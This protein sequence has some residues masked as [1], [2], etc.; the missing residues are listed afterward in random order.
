MIAAPGQKN[1]CGVY[2]PTETLAL[3]QPNRKGWRGS[4]LA[5]IDI[6]RTSEG[7]RAVHGIQFLTGSCWGSSSPLMD[8]D[9]AFNSRDAA[10]EHQVA[11][12][13]ERVTKYGEREPG[14]LRD[15]RA[16]L[17]WLDNLRPVQADL[18]AALA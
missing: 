5:E 12:L 8:R 10:I 13:R 14:A 2:T 4:P 6:V 7:W 11:R 1:D 16:I 3:P 15:V 9:T 17:A 18:F